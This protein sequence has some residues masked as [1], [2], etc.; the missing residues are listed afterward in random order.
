MA[1]FTSLG[2]HVPVALPYLIAEGILPKDPPRELYQWETYVFDEGHGDVEEELLVT[3]T[4]V[5]WSQGKFVRNVYRFDLEGEDMIQALLT[6]FPLPE[7]TSLGGRSEPN[8]ANHDTK[9][10]QQRAPSSRPPN[11]SG[12]S[13]RKEADRIALTS[14]RA[15]VVFL[16]SKAHIYFLHGSSHIIDLPFEV[17]RAFPAPRGV[18]MQRKV[19][20]LP[21]LPPTPKLPAAPPN[22]FFSSQ[23]QPSSSY[24]QSPTIA[25]SFSSTQ[26]GRPSPLSGKN[27]LNSLLQDILG[28]PAEDVEEDTATLYSLSNPLSEVGVITYSLQHPKP[29][30]SSKAKGGLSVEFEPLDAAEDVIYVSPTDELT[31]N[32]KHGHLPL[33]LIVT[34]NKDMQMLTVWHAWYVDER[35]LAS[36]LKQRAEHKAAKARRR[37]SF[38]SAGMATGTATPA[39]RHR[40]GTR[41]SFAGAGLMRLPGEPLASQPTAGS[42]RKPTR[43]EEEDAMASQMD[44]DYQPT[45]S[46]HTARDSR[47]ISSL[48]TDVRASQHNV[49][50]SF[51]GAVGRRNASFGGPNERRSLGHRKSRGS[52]PGSVFGRS[53]GADDDLMDVD[54]SMDTDGDETVDGIVRHVRATFEAA[55]AESIFGSSDEGFR[56]ELIVRKLHSFQMASASGS[57]SD[58]SHKTRVVTL[59]DAFPLHNSDDQ[60]INIYIHESHTT[61]LRCLRLLVRQRELWPELSD[62]Q[63][64]SVPIVIGDVVLGQ[65][66][67]I[68]KLK[69][70]RA[71]A[72]LSTPSGLIFSLD[73]KTP[74]PLPTLPA[75]RMYHPMA[76]LSLGGHTDEDIGRNRVLQGPDRNTLRLINA[77][78]IGRFDELGSDGVCHRLQMRLRPKEKYINQLLGMCRCIL[79]ARQSQMVSGIWCL[80][81]VELEKHPEKFS[82]TAV[83]IES[84]AF[85]ATVFMF[86]RHVIDDKA[87]AALTLSRVAAS[88][89]PGIS[90]LQ[91]STSQYET[92]QSSRP[93]WSWMEE[94]RLAPHGS[95]ASPQEDGQEARRDQLIPIAD[96]LA[97]ELL[98]S[99]VRTSAGESYALSGDDAVKLV[100]GLHILN[101]EQK[102]CILSSKERRSNFLAPLI[103][104]LGNWLGLDAW[105]YG[106]GQYYDLEGANEQQ[107]A[108]VKSRTQP[109]AQT[110]LMEEPVGVF[111]WF[112]HSLNV[113][114]GERYPTL[115]IIANLNSAAVSSKSLHEAATGMTPRIAMLSDILAATAGFSAPAT[116]T[117]ELMARYGITAGEMETLPEAIAV[118]FRDA[119]SRCEREPPTIW[120]TELL[121]LIGR[122][123]LTGDSNDHSPLP[124]TTSTNSVSTPKDVQTICHALDHPPH[125][126]KTKEAG[127]HAVSQLIF[128]EDRRLVEATSLMHY[129]SVQVAECPKQPD[130]SD[131][132][133]FEQQRR[134]MQWV[135]LRMIAIPAGDAMIHYDSQTLLLTDKYHLPGFSSS[136]LM[137]PMGHTLTTD[138]S[139]LTEEKVNWAYFH[140]GASAG[141]RISR[142]VTGI[143]TS[144]IAFNKPNELTNRHAGLLLSLGLS[145][146]LRHLA[147]WLSFKYLTPKH[148]MTSVGLLLGLS[149]SYMGT[150][151]G[152]ITRMLSVHITRMLPPG[153]AELNV[154]PITQTAGL[155]GIGLLYYNTQHRRMSEIMLSEVEHMESEDPDSGPDPLRDESYRLAAGL[156]LGYINLGK[157]KDLRGLHGMYL[158]ERL[159]AVAV[160][161]RPVN[162]VHVFDRA[163]AGAVIA[164]ALV[165]MKSGDKAVARKIDIPDTETQFDH[166]R[167][168]MLMLRAMA[169]HII[170][171]DAIQ[172]S[173]SSPVVP[174]WIQANL[175]A[176]YRARFRDINAS[177]GRHPLK[178]SD[179]PFFNI[180]TGL[181]WALSLRYAGSGNVDAR[182]E[183]LTILDYFYMVKGGGDAYYYDA[184]LARS[185]VRRC[186]DVL[187]LAAATVMAG[188]GDI[189]TFR[190]LRRLHGRTDAET[191]YGSHL[192][193]HLAIGTL[194]LGGG[195]FTFGT[196]NLAVASLIC[197]FYPLFPTD[198]HDNHVHLQALR[199]FWVFAT[200]ARCLVVEE[201]DTHRPISMPILLTLTDG[202]T[203]SLTAPCLLP[204]LNTIARV[205][206]ND[207]AYW[208]VTLDFAGNPKHLSTFR[209]NQHIFVRRCPA[210]EAHHTVFSATLAAMNDAQSSSQLTSQ[211]I[212]H[213]VFDLPVFKELDKADTELILPPDVHS[214]VVMDEKGTVVDDRLLLANAV[215]SR[216]KDALWNLRVLFAWAGRAR[217]EGSGGLRWIGNEAVEALK[218]KVD[219]R[220]REV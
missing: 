130:W 80:A 125:S 13:S 219:E 129:N 152:L 26:P 193:A 209:Q 22:S 20:S 107:W 147:K 151:D 141:L 183:I 153:A 16:R 3:K 108:F 42:S 206:T 114:A 160:G 205:Q 43:E 200:E 6:R 91:L 182:D 85:A 154:S 210:S 60:R 132:H 74:L 126:A 89:A 79:P 166:V 122:K 190:Y 96:A 71:E 201:C 33:M 212:W 39:V 213:S 191:P 138:R 7:T 169:K 2:V 14:A 214:A 204:E 52:T 171:W 172:V 4:C 17:A 82:G 198:V 93:P 162:A 180:A 112:E 75:Y 30:L 62:S 104:Q 120:T 84:L 78:A 11:H 203:K 157:G 1:E 55:G 196:S 37:S 208:R 170:L 18:V 45:A 70:S 188:T 128:S 103:A 61:R 97:D 53:I 199:H 140:A 56:R 148:T 167:P 156:A 73:A 48:N 189:K 145:G 133:H 215:G 19:L 192:A 94:H 27:R 197:A 63:S 92:Q 9:T 81:V 158:P 155:V 135:T 8:V 143:D 50:A 59:K 175:P 181:A 38:L 179:V 105:S 165:Y 137:Q 69:D 86:V 65:C 178:S 15:L 64:V 35:S 57:T 29:R 90:S 44:P 184:K 67:D 136:C 23:L 100:L 99:T 21:A 28:T 123:D 139:G 40:E 121:S 168:D 88:K 54:N 176:C 116:T 146:H 12:T 118:P 217:D 83:G 142:N 134:V 117:V 68:V 109:Q 218:A 207:P 95:A 220:M 32:A 164:I 5:V 66:I 58:A 174:S 195:T 46:Q 186:I 24:L 159:L 187:A 51:G 76:G 216:E 101:E 87:R 111:H 10:A 34:A 41:E 115:D 47:R 72:I 194:F 36:L 150:T 113:G 119:I 177:S 185:T 149:A 49:G 110:S 77:G 173:G 98:Q 31:S 124:S 202:S 25:K 163:T 131:A 102:L 127:R 211:H 106:A 161:P 144:W